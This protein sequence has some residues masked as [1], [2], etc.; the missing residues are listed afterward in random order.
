MIRPTVTSEF[1]APRRLPG[2]VPPEDLYGL[3]GPILDHLADETRGFTAGVRGASSPEY[4][5]AEAFIPAQHFRPGSGRAPR[6]ISQIVIHVTAGQAD[7]R[8][9]VKYFQ[10]PTRH[11][12]PLCVSAHYVIGQ[13]GEV[14]QMVRHDDVAFH[15][16][17]ANA[18]SIGIEHVA[19]PPGEWSASDEGLFPTP[20]E[21]LASARLVH[22]LCRRYGLPL[23]RAHILGH[24]EA[25]P[26]T[27]HTNC[28]DGAWNWDYFMGV[29]ASVS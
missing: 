24:V 2:C 19:R 29:L 7:Y 22:F 14:V 5:E 11:S 4:P 9:T 10:H 12:E 13:G 25:D 6:A 21:Y 1:K 8:R 23:D 20:Q 16:R 28:P 15:A 18:R 27:S 26:E 3:E 17:S